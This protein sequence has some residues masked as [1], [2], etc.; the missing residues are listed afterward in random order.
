MDHLDEL[1]PMPPPARSDSHLM[2]NPYYLLSLLGMVINPAAYMV[3]EV[4]NSLHEIEQLL[5]QS[6]SEVCNIIKIP[7][8]NANCHAPDPLESS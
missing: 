2:V 8:T 6:G 4:Q 7:L 1:L 5:G 3:A